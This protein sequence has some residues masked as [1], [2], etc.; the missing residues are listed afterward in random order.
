VVDAVYQQ[1]SRRIDEKDLTIPEIKAVGSFECAV[2]LHP[3][4]TGTFTVVVQKEKAVQGGKK[5]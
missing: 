2:V 1:T 5:K 4:V 3:E